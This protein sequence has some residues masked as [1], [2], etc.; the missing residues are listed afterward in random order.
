MV[1]ETQDHVEDSRI[2]WI[3][4]KISSNY[5]ISKNKWKDFIGN[6]DTKYACFDTNRKKNNQSV[7]V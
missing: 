3:S 7:L 4:N 2:E 6:E 5:K 1:E